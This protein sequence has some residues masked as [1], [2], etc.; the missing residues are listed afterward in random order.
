[1]GIAVQALDGVYGRPAASVR[2]RLEHADNG[3]WNAEDKAETDQEGRVREWCG[4]KFERGL[5]RIVFESDRYFVGLG[6]SAAYPEIVVTF[7]MQDQT[8]SYQIQLLL[9]TYSYSAYFGSLS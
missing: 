5:Y 4:R 3:Q 8:D 2:V 7:R 1:M 6:L 9:S